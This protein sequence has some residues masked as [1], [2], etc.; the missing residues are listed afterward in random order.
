MKSPSLV[1]STMPPEPVPS[2]PEAML[3][4][5]RPGIAY[6]VCG[7]ES[8]VTFATSSIVRTRRGFIGSV[9]TSKMKKRLLLS[10]AAQIF[11]RSS[12]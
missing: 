12:V 11:A 9:P 2:G 4:R 8:P 7:P 6:G 5:I 10:D 3:T 1:N